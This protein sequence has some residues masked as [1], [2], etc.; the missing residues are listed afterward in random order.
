MRNLTPL[1]IEEIYRATLRTEGIQTPLSPKPLRVAH[2]THLDFLALVSC[3]TAH[4][5]QTAAPTAIAAQTLLADLV[6]ARPLDDTA[7]LVIRV[8]R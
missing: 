1:D 7:F 2:L 3:L 5:F 6:N 8:E 4:P